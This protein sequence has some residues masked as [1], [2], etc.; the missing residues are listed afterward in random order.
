M[1]TPLPVPG[2][3]LKCTYHR[4]GA[5]VRRRRRDPRSPL[6]G[7]EAR[8][9]AD[10]RSP[11]TIRTCRARGP[12][13]PRVGGQLLRHHTLAPPARLT[14][15]TVVAALSSSVRYR[16][17]C[18]GRPGAAGGAFVIVHARA[19]LKITA[20]IHGRSEAAAH[21][22][23]ADAAVRVAV[24]RRGAARGTAS[25]RTCSA[26]WSSRSRGCRASTPSCPRH[27]TAA[28]HRGRKY[29]GGAHGPGS[30]RSHH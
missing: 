11:V 22:H 24:T 4:G 21:D 25:R 28:A 8:A 17:R 13:L 29:R 7:D 19:S 2:D 16:A 3:I 6:R 10:T 15:F 20:R 12:A 30:R 5:C 1:G 9:N 27:K 26:G 14:Y 18:G 23:A